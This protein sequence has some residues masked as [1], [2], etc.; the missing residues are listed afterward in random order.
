[1]CL[2]GDFINGVCRRGFP[3]YLGSRD[4][5]RMYERGFDGL[6]DEEEDEEEEEEEDLYG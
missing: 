5:T 2:K 4:F 1:M 6:E 3:L